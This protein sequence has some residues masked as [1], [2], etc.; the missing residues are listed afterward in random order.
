[1]P[2][3]NR[4]PVNPDAFRG[5]AR[6]LPSQPGPGSSR[7]AAELAGSVVALLFYSA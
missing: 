4:Q 7:A 5:L 1:L 2:G 3:A 6:L